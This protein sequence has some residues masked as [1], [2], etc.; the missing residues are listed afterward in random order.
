MDF[1][2]RCIRDDS[3]QFYTSK[4]QSFRFSFK[5]FKF[6]GFPKRMVV[7][8]CDVAI[9]DVEDSESFCARRCAAKKARSKRGGKQY[10]GKLWYPHEITQLDTHAYKFYNGTL[11]CSPFIAY[12]AD[13]TLEN[14]KKTEIL[15]INIGKI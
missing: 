11:W 3:V 5:T 9:C 10:S 14:N 2:C 13:C 4:D 8:H 12:A 1:Y 6:I 15:F 7:T